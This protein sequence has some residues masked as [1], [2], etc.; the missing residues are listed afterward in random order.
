VKSL[1]EDVLFH[2]RVVDEICNKAQDLQG[3]S[4]EQD[5][6]SV[7]NKYENLLTMTQVIVCVFLVTSSN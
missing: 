7:K 2:G 1:L 3:F 4:N 6:T 5:L